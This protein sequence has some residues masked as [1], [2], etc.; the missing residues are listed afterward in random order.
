M[1][2]I[3]TKATPTASLEAATKGWTIRP[4]R[5]L[6]EVLPNSGQSA[7]GLCGFQIVCDYQRVQSGTDPFLSHTCTS[8]CAS[9]LTDLR[10]ECSRGD[11]RSCP[12]FRRIILFVRVSDYSVFTTRFWFYVVLQVCFTHRT[13]ISLAPSIHV[14]KR[15]LHVQ[16][17]CHCNGFVNIFR[18]VRN[19][20]QS[21]AREIRNTNNA[22]VFVLLLDR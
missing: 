10:Y 3:K 21:E 17:M 5:S 2:T 22:M 8:L 18:H 19:S 11:I 16:L 6:V 9:L 15:H 4:S 14:S 7:D 1:R 13:D 20:A 12:T